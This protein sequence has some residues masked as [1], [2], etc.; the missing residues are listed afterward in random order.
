[1][2]DD[3]GAS[4]YSLQTCETAYLQFPRIGYAVARLS[5]HLRRSYVGCVSGQGPTMAIEGSNA[6]SWIVIDET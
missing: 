1:M 4:S 3:T 2:I 6:D 5:R